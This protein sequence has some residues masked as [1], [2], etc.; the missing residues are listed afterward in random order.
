MKSILVTLMASLAFAGLLH[1]Q[2]QGG[3]FADVPPNHYA[4]TQVETIAELGIT[5]GCSVVPP[6][7]CPDA[8]IT[9]GELSVF[10]VTALGQSP[11]TCTG[12]FFDIP[13]S[14]PF[15]GFIEKIVEDRIMAGCA[16]PIPPP[17]PPIDP[18]TGAFCPD[19]RV[20]R[21]EMAMYIEGALTGTLFPFLTD[22]KGTVFLDVTPTSTEYCGYIEKLA[23]RGMTGGCG[24]GNF[25]PEA[26]CDSIPDVSI[27]G[28]GAAAVETFLRGNCRLSLSRG[29][30]LRR[31]SE[32]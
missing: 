16:I 1:A 24:G 21:E 3:R 9:R 13:L 14:H 10:L 11:N 7:F 15:C 23:A 22:C 4:F 29:T 8:P 17:G 31:H 19:R 32:R 18:F 26:S 30:D 20:S 27:P 12:Q 28:Y 5:G 25:C 2:I 6:L